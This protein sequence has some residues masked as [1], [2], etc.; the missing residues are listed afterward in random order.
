M[1]KT[2]EKYELMYIINPNLSEEETAAIVEKFKALVEQHGTLEEM[3]EMGKRKLAYEINYIS[4]G[5]YVLVKFTSGPEFP[6]ELDRVLGIT[7]GVMRSLITLR[8]E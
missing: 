4:E 5:Y 1:A 3:E 8:A 7:D 6:A 2:S